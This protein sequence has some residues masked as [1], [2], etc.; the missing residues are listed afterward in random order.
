MMDWLVEFFRY[1][2]DNLLVSGTYDLTLVG[3]SVFLAIFSSF[4]AL[5]LVSQTEDFTSSLQRKLALLAG[6]F[7]LGCGVWSM[8]FIGMLA[9]DLCTTVD[10]D[11]KLTIISM[12]PSI[13]AS[14]VALNIIAKPNATNVE[15]VIGGTLVGA[16]IGI[17]HYVGMEA[18]QMAPLVRYDI[19][20]FVLSIA[21]AV[22]LAILSL[23]VRFGI[24][25]FHRFHVSE[26]NLN[27]ISAVIMGLAISGMHYIGMLAARFISYGELI[28]DDSSTDSAFL[29]IG[30]AIIVLFTTFFVLGVNLVIKYRDVSLSTRSNEKRLKAIMET[31][32][33]GVVT[34]NAHGFIMDANNAVTTI[35][36]WKPDELTGKNVSILTPPEIAHQHDSFLERYLKTHEAKIIGKGREVDALHKLGHRVPIRLA[37]GHVQLPNEDFFVGFISDIS[38]RLD[39]E[40]NI[41]ESE[42]K[43]RTLIGNIPGAAYRCNCDK[44]WHM[45][46]VSEA[47]E[48]ITGY[49]AEEFLEQ[50]NKVSFGHIIHPDDVELTNGV[51]ETTEGFQ[52]EYRIYHKDGSIRWVLDAGICIRDEQGEIVC[53][54]G[55]LMDIT[56]RKLMEHQL[57]QEKERAERATAIKSEFLANMSHEIR[58]PMNAILGFSEILLDSD[59]SNDQRKHLCIISNAAHSLLHLIDDILDSAKMEKGKLTLEHLHFSLR[60]Q[61]DLVISTMWVQAR[62]KSLAL[63]LEIDPEIQ[64]FYV[65]ARDRIRQVLINL[66]GNAIKFTKQGRVVLQ[67]TLAEEGFVHFKVSDTGIGISADRLEHIFD[68]FTQ[69]DA[70]MTRRF[71]GTGLGTSISKQLVELMGGSISV[72]SVVGE[73]SCF[74]FSIP[75]TVGDADKAATESAQTISLEPMSILIAD[76]IKQNRELLK[77]YFG[78]QGHRVTTASDGEG[79]T[80]L[81]KQH[82]FDVVL[83]DVQMPIIDGH[84]AARIVRE[85]EKQQSRPPVPII[86]LTA[87]VLEEDKVAA[88]EAGMDGFAS[89]PVN[90]NELTAEI[91][92]LTGKSLRAVDTEQDCLVAASNGLVNMQE[93]LSLW[94]ESSIYIKEL[95]LFL[96]QNSNLIAT[97]NNLVTS[98]DAPALL[99]KAHSL[100]G[101]VGNL[102]IRK[103]EEQFLLLEDTVT[104][105]QFESSTAII[106]RIGQLYAELQTECDNLREQFNNASANDVEALESSTDPTPFKESI[107]DLINIAKASEFDEE[108]LNVLMKHADAKNKQR[109]LAIQ[110]AFE[111]FDFDVALS[112]LQDL[113]NELPDKE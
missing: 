95:S 70:S 96:Q 66:I 61:L 2:D 87:S 98:N 15:L 113:A 42:E 4:M 10:Y 33:D 99:Q 64:E 52:V 37:I 59:L 46:F 101:I 92:R 51:V 69:A 67:V 11:W 90:F 85:W 62:K 86:A 45:Q 9:F 3:L 34:I 78:R 6:S 68:P 80:K 65:G 21:C 110:R 13:A 30:I 18:M 8:H 38:A 7:A 81:I 77:L 16:G 55:F 88:R 27:V 41:R 57:V 111:D 63:E 14:W 108:A 26:L 25:R 82:P 100:R 112:L 71:G 47:V 31:A 39:M 12:L 43:F 73:G 93:A 35:L 79:A 76:D 50:N 22:T 36:G 91:A 54:D 28:K 5:Q 104:H 109:V 106:E 102:A 48:G 83:M 84:M 105:Y 107:L 97:L 29:S 103:L 32:V 20:Y 74:E 56:E 1:P 53:L 49:T 24:R 40:K 94:Q 44:D 17:M 72:S 60:Q 89:K 75:L 19:T 23:S 58:T